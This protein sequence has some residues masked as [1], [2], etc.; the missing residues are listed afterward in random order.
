MHGKVIKKETY[1]GGEKRKNI[2]KRND[3]KKRKTGILTGR[4]KT[5]DFKE[6]LLWIIA[7]VLSGC[8]SY[9]MIKGT[10]KENIK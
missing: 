10:K 6:P 7:A 9:A 4:V 3:T 5:G 2:K 8:I 1:F